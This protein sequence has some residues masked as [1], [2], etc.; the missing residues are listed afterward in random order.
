M[1]RFKELPEAKRHAKRYAKRTDQPHLIYRLQSNPR[2][3]V[4]PGDHPVQRSYE[5][6]ALTLG[7]AR[8]VHTAR[9]PS[10]NP[11][12]HVGG[13]CLVGEHAAGKRYPCDDDFEDTKTGEMVN[14][15]TTMSGHLALPTRYGGKV[16][17]LAE[18]EKQPGVKKGS[19]RKW[20]TKPTKNPGVSSAMRRLLR[21]P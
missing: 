17:K 18:I 21:G 4:V 2:Y 1:R 14:F 3:A 10:P 12:E 6:G 5:Q 8:L 7:N 13:G 19:A 11:W 20:K 9:P 16:K 15:S